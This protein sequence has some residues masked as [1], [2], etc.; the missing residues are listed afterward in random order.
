MQNFVSRHVKLLSKGFITIRYS[1][2]R[3]LKHLDH[4]LCISIQSILRCQLPLSWILFDKHIQ[5]D[6][7]DSTCTNL[8]ASHIIHIHLHEQSKYAF[9]DATLPFIWHQTIL[10]DIDSHDFISSQITRCC[11]R[12][13]MPRRMSVSIKFKNNFGLGVYPAYGHQSMKLGSNVELQ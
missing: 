9:H 4:N 13:K 7:S 5:F 3:L 1:S 12:D 8:N 11:R 10:H 6:I 2:L